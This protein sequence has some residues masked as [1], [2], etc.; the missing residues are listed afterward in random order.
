MA[1]RLKSGGWGQRDVRCPFWRGE[2]DR[3]VCCEGLRPGE[4]IRRLL[5]DKDAK[6]R[7]MRAFCCGGYDQCPVYGLVMGIK[8]RDL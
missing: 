3:A 4:T 5:P 8:Y 2:T 1:E 6:L 7:E